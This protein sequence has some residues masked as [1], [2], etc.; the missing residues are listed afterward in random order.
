M[1][2]NTLDE[3]LSWQETLHPAEIDLGLARVRAVYERLGVTLHCPVIT[4][5][6][7]NGKGSSVAMLAAIYQAAGYR[8]G[9]YTSP[10]CCVTT[11]ASALRVTR[12]PMRRC[13]RPL[14]V[15]IK[16][17]ARPRSPTLNLAPLLRLISSAAPRSMW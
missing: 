11:N 8:V 1:R 13:V 4:V 9:V 12:L 15:L 14:S 7:T 17:V 10:I 6:G 2:F 16:R 3:W 5:A